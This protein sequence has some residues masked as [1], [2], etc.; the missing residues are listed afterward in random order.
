MFYDQCVEIYHDL[1]QN[2]F[3]Q[4]ILDIAISLPVF[5]LGRAPKPEVIRTNVK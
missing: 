2:R 5:D 3:W 1:T 4:S